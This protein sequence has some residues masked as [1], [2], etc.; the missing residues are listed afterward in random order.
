MLL[1]DDFQDLHGACLDADAASNALGGNRR[2]LSLDHNA[3]GTCF[4]ALA[5]ADTELLVDGVDTLCILSDSTNFTSSC[6]LA[7]LDANHGLSNALAIYDLDA[8]LIRME[9]LI[10]C[11]GTCTNALETCHTGGA[12]FDSEFFHGNSPFFVFK[13]CSYYTWYSSINQSIF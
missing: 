8:G 13:I 1:F 2:R 9:L 4:Q 5:T 11:V 10:E 3:E 6:T 12:F 7:A